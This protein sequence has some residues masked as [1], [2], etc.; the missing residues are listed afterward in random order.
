MSTIGAHVKHNFEKGFLLDEE[1]LRKIHD[2]ISKRIVDNNIEYSVYQVDSYSFKSKK[3]EDVINYENSKL[4]KISRLEIG[5]EKKFTDLDLSLYFDGSEELGARL[6]IEGKNRDNVFLLSSELKE[7]ISNEVCTQRITK[8]I[9]SKLSF[10]FAIGFGILFFVL[11]F[12]G[13]RN[14]NASISRDIIDTVLK[15]NDTNEKINLLI[16][17]NFEDNLKTKN[18][19]SNT[20]YVGWLSWLLYMVFLVYYDKLGKAMSYFFPANLFLFGKEIERYNKLL[21]TRSKIVWSIGIAL[22]ISIV[23]GLIVWQM[24]LKT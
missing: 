14:T 11:I 21:D 4:S 12:L 3:I 16:Q 5:L 10:Y 9:L 17:K 2:I 1:K 8:N 22:F 7:Y 19:N 24:T 23:G 15:S 13:N 18:T 6:H 20:I